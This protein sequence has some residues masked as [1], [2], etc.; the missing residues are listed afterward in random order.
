MSEKTLIVPVLERAKEAMNAKSDYELAQKL[1]VTTAAMSGYK[2]RKS[3][4]LE[5]C[6]KI[7][8]IS[9]VSLDWLI[10][11]KGN[12]YGVPAS[13]KPTPKQLLTLKDKEHRIWLEM[14]SY[15][16]GN[17]DL[18]LTESE[19]K[20]ACLLKKVTAEISE[21]KF[22][23][24]NPNL[25]KLLTNLEKRKFEY[26][27]DEIEQQ[28]DIQNNQLNPEQKMLLTGFDSL[29]SEQQDC[30]FN[31]IRRFVRG[32]E[33]ACSKPAI[34]ISG[35]NVGQANAGNG[36]IENLNIKNDKG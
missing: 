21:I 2:K 17:Q 6:I 28:T 16:L 12:K 36:Y 19:T 4:P 35:G 10:L 3:L 5:Q 30:I 13:H 29:T 20:L 24:A 9:S 1:G 32:E 27:V 33:V 26:P 8:Q 15:D 34:H 7:A 31:F 14:L 22:Y 23:Q 25:V 18:P 11:N